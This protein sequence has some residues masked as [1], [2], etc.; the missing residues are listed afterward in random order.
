MIEFGL[1]ERKAASGEALTVAEAGEILASGD[2][3]AIGVLGEA[4]RKARAGDQV[5]YGRVAEVDAA[6]AMPEVGEAGEVR[7]TGAPASAGDARE[8]T[9]R[10]AEQAAGRPLTGFTL[11]DLLA[12][13]GGDLAALR[14]LCGTLRDAGLVAI[15]EVPVDRFTDAGALVTA[16]RAAIDG[17]LLVLRGTIERAAADDRL[18]LIARAGVL[19]RDTRALRAFAPLPRIDPVE[20][21]STGYDDVRTVAAARLMLTDV[22]AI[23]VDW[24]L[25]GPKLAQ[26]A[27]AFGASDIDGVAAVDTLQLGHRRSPKADIERQI[28]AAGA[29]P[30]ERDGRYELRR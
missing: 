8:R 21:P 19:Q 26:V 10:A 1:L 4:A 12:L 14:R 29:V 22:P 6:T 7:L 23:Q 17:G 25:Y 24:P 30:A 3:V 27:I 11:A 28:R 5:T 2:L 13:A 20:T 16:V 9:R 15:A 18:A